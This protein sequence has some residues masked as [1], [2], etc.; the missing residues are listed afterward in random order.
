LLYSKKLRA[1]LLGSTAL[2]AGAFMLA[3]GG[4]A[5]A[6]LVA[7][8]CDGGPAS[9]GGSITCSGDH[10]YA[11]ISNFDDLTVTLNADANVSYIGGPVIQFYGASNDLILKE[12]SNL[13]SFDAYSAVVLGDED[14]TVTLN[15]GASITLYGYGGSGLNKTVEAGGKGSA[16]TLNGGSSIVFVGAGGERKYASGTAV[17]LDG[18]NASLVLNGG[19]SVDVTGGSTYGSAPYAYNKYTG[20]RAVNISQTILL[21]GGSTVNL[22]GTGDG[23]G[24]YIGIDAQGGYAK[25]ADEAGSITLNGGSSVNVSTPGGSYNTVT[26]VAVGYGGRKKARVRRGGGYASSLTLNGSSSIN[27]GDADGGLDVGRRVMGRENKYIGASF[28]GHDGVLTL[29][30]TSSINVTPAPGSASGIGID[31][32]AQNSEVTLNG[33]SSVSVSGEASYAAYGI[34]LY[35]GA[36]VVT[37]N[38][39]SSVQANGSGGY[40]AAVSMRGY[41]NDLVLNDESLVASSNGLGVV[42]WRGN[43]NNVEMNGDASVQ[44][45]GTGIALIDQRSATLTLNDNASV[46]AETG[47]GIVVDYANNT[48]ITLNGSSSVVGDKAGIVVLGEYEDCCDTYYSHDVEIFVNAGA[49]VTGKTGIV[50][51]ENTYNS[52]IFVGG[53]VTGT[54]GTA[55]DFS[56]AGNNTLILGTGAVLN[57]D[58]VGADGGVDALVLTGQGVLSADVSDFD[59]LHVEADGIWN[60]TSDLNLSNGPDY[61]VVIETGELAVNATLTTGTVTILEGGTLGGSGIIIGDIDNF[62][63]IA[64]GNSPG[65]L[66]VVGNVTFNPGSGLVVQVENGVADLINVTGGDVTIDPGTSITMQ[67][68]GG[69]DGF[70]GEVITTD[71]NVIGTFTSFIG[72][73]F[74]YS[75]PGIV[76]L[77]SAS[78][79]SINGAMSGGAS[80]GFTFLDAVLGNAETGVGTGKSLWSTGLWQNADRSSTSTARGSNQRS[81]GFA[82]GGDV[83]QVGSLTLG[84]AAGYIDSDVETVG[85]GTKTGIKG[86]NGALYGAY[87]FGNTFAT[88]AVTVAWQDQDVKRNVLSGGTIVTANSSPKAFATGAGL[89]VGHVIPIE[90]AWTLTPKASLGWQH[91]TR[92]AYSETG[93]G[94]GAMSVNEVSSDTLRAQVGAEL[95]LTIKAPDANWTV[96]PAIRAAVARETRS[97]D[98]LATGRFLA[99]GTAFGAQLDNRNQTYLA[100]GAGVDVK[101]GNGITAFVDYDGGFGGDA[102]KS[103]GVRIGARLEW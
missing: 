55:I 13:I 48:V 45:Y 32:N 90:G 64:P 31:V 72:G 88:T 11:M 7:E 43:Y 100:V 5:S 94:L 85:G 28:G 18:E 102:E 103:G 87:G 2:F 34:R 91:V 20:V 70:V 62:G 19:S 65:T 41:Y 10:T 47:E 30:D 36:N 67:F 92:D 89:T 9:A 1:R 37:L 57:G 71:Q 15:G 38:G 42:V 12:S 40:V 63:T 74:D 21:N 51:A 97:G 6:E 73:T 26:G 83:L 23:Y 60:L 66:N 84:L 78:P 50:F 77:T 58:V 96:R 33:S 59:F 16:I 56:D 4:T 3:A 54:M 53:T 17:A 24:R 39:T 46:V 81:R 22:T 99:S 52:Q 76:S 29:N 98:D 27:V 93:G 69:V 79:S 25:Y 86:Y 95:A 101:I 68:L 8:P 35:G 14:G 44:A 61:G 80:V 82:F 49:S 75:V